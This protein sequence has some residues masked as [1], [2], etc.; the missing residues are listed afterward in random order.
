MNNF[1][2]FMRSPAGRTLRIVLGLFLIWW[3]FWGDAGVIVG[4]IGFVPLAAGT[5][6]FCLF[7]PLFG[8]TIWGEAKTA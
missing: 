2:G 4:M 5:V 8:R 6:N 3:G 7:A 1:V